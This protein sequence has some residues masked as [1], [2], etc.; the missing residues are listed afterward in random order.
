[1]CSE[2]MA[3]FARP[4][5]RS[6]PFARPDIHGPH[7]HGL[8]VK[9]KKYKKNGKRWTI[10]QMQLPTY[11]QKKKKEFNMGPICG[12]ATWAFCLQEF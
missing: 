6:A 11:P 3:P 9:K 10:R 4:Y 1:M 5:M 7:L 2:E 12:Q 8:E